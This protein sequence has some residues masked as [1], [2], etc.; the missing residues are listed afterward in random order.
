MITQ[1]LIKG[2]KA[3]GNFLSGILFRSIESLNKFDNHLVYHIKCDL[4]KEANNMAKKGTSIDNGVLRVN[5][6]SRLF[7]IP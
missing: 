5:G 2:S 4:N 6:I 7:P 3:G 1:V